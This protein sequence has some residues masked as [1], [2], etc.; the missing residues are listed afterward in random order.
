MTERVGI[1]M[2]RVGNWK[3]KESR[4]EIDYDRR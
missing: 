2:E 1:E 4:K 3:T